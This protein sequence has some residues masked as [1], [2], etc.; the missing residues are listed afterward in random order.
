MLV[1]NFNSDETHEYMVEGRGLR[2]ILP[3]LIRIATQQM[4]TNSEGA[5]GSRSETVQLPPRGASCQS[6]HERAT[7]QA[8][9]KFRHIIGDVPG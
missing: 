5:W 9:Q 6:G 7:K 1:P 8:E 2:S 4:K 3:S